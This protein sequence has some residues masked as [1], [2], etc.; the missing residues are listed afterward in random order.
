[1]PPT[2]TPVA[3]PPKPR[4]PA[5]ATGPLPVGPYRSTKRYCERWEAEHNVGVAE[6]E[7]HCN[8]QPDAQECISGCGFA[9]A[10]RITAMTS[11]GAAFASVELV[12]LSGPC[13]SP[14]CYLALGTSDGVWLVNEVF[15]CGGGE[16]MVGSLDTIALVVDGDQLVWRYAHRFGEMGAAQSETGIVRCRATSGAPRCDDETTPAP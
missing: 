13:G 8:E 7:R 4:E 11:P 12:E 15:Q 16:G 2:V 6:Q 14:S 1:V 10:C 9:S 3:P 5:I